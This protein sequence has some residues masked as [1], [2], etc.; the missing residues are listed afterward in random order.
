M[1]PDS[2]SKAHQKPASCQGASRAHLRRPQQK[3]VPSVC[4]STLRWGPPSPKVTEQKP[5]N[6]AASTL[7]AALD[8]PGMERGDSPHSA[9]G[10]TEAGRDGGGGGWGPGA[11]GG[12]SPAGSLRWRER[13]NRKVTA[14]VK[15]GGAEPA[16]R[17]AHL[18][19]E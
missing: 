19:R 9:E 16:S 12:L 3:P 6:G 4:A 14:T 13:V 2:K 7:G 1:P 5:G 11:Q 15:S 17:G 8:A 18:G 10:E